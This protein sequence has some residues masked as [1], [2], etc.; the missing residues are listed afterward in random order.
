MSA[1]LQGVQLVVSPHR[2]VTSI[3]FKRVDQGYITH[4]CPVGRLVS[5]HQIHELDVHVPVVVQQREA[6]G[7]VHSLML[8]SSKQ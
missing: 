6:L 8:A 4:D 2:P 3:T 1:L 7:L 5:Q